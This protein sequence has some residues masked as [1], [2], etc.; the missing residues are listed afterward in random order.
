M[1]VVCYKKKKLNQK[2]KKKMYRINNYFYKFVYSM[3]AD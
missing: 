1:Q 3:K 2:L